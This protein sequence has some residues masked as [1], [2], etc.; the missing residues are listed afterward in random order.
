[1]WGKT[2]IYVLNK[3]FSH[4]FLKTIYIIFFYLTC[5]GTTAPSF[6]TTKGVGN[7][8]RFFI[9][10]IK[11]GVPQIG[12]HSVIIQARISRRVANASWKFF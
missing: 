5:K 1:M 4:H 6:S 2:N 7:L 9:I 8:R 3:K 12:E 10:P 11:P